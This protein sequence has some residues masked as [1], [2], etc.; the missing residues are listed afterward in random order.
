MRLFPFLHKGN[1]KTV[2]NSL[3]NDIAFLYPL[4]LVSALFKKQSRCLSLQFY[5]SIFFI[6]LLKRVS[7]KILLSN[8]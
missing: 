6:S 8:F 3:Y 7:I 2:K 1:T 5:I 4:I